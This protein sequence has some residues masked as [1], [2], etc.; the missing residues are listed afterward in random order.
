MSASHF[1]DQLEPDN[2]D[3][4]LDL[5]LV[6]LG[7]LLVLQIPVRTHELG[8][9]LVAED[10]ETEVAVEVDKLFLGYIAFRSQGHQTE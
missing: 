10:V 4:L 8:K 1:L 5:F 7:L 2:A 9:C 6:L 3:G